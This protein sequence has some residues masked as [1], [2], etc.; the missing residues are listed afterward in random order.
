MRLLD[1]FR[2][3]PEAKESATGRA[4]VMT[5]GQPVWTPR[6]YAAF[7]KEAYAINVVAYQAINRVCDAVASVPVMLFR[8]KDEITES[9]LLSLLR[10]PNPLQGFDDY[11]RSL[12]GFYLLSGNA[13]QERVDI[14]GAPRELYCLRPD[15]MKVV[16]SQTGMPSAYEY[17]VNGRTVRWDFDPDNVPASLIWHTKTFNP[18]SDWYGM[19]PVEAAAYSIDT[20]NEGARWMQG[21]LQN[22]AR[23]SGALVTKADTQLSDDAFHRLKAEMEEQYQGGRNAGRPML[24]EG[25][26]DWK[27][28]GFSP[29]DMG[30]L[31][32]RYSSAREICL[33]FGVPPMLLGIPGDNTYSNY[34]EARLSFWEDT[35]LPLIDVIYGGWNVWLA[36][37]FGEGLELRPDLEQIPAIVE[38]RHQLWKMADASTDL[39]LNERR[40]MKGYDPV[41]GGNVVLVPMNLLP[42]GEDQAAMPE[43]IKAAAALAGYPDNVTPLD[44]KAK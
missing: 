27:A 8:G 3:A 19:S 34:A 25:G 40:A 30:I 37:R 2:R 1:L 38:K 7:S 6:E 17:A 39:T 18:L 26:L 24:L 5:P 28:M 41:P 36:P 31:E 44:R 42:L 33:A 11:V 35:V 9:P 4:V 15:R 21:L 23:P 13:Y 22:S 12:V 43:D 29:D 32:S 10:R 20:H 16:P 14:G